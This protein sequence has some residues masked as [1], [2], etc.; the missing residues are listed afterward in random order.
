MVVQEGGG[1]CKAGLF[2][3]LKYGILKIHCFINFMVWT[4]CGH[5]I[6]Y[7][8]ENSF[9]TPVLV[10][11]GNFFYQLTFQFIPLN[12]WL[13]SCMWSIL[14][15]DQSKVCNL[16]WLCMRCPQRPMARRM[17]SEGGRGER[18]WYISVA[19]ESISVC[20]VN[21]VSVPLA[22]I[23]EWKVEQHSTPKSHYQIGQ[24][25]RF[26]PNKP[27]LFFFFFFCYRGLKPGF[28]EP[29][30]WLWGWALSGTFSLC[31]TEYYLRLYQGFFVHARPKSNMIFKF[32]FI[33]SRALKSNK[34]K[35]AW[36]KLSSA[37]RNASHIKHEVKCLCADL[38]LFK[39][40][41]RNL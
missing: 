4:E 12:F 9:K 33:L 25:S 17:D 10:T 6:S 3:G 21:L 24:V 22:E 19:P 14:P 26:P 23:S 28:S 2:G 1:E 40:Y 38:T 30:G 34:R 16:W 41:K 36:L 31:A 7:S 20:S 35:L 15:I 29:Q 11:N 37:G 39:W 32:Y 13:Q 8:K 18:K 5:V 27:P